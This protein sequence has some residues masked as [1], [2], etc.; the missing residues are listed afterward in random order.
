MGADINSVNN[1][2][3]TARHYAV[4]GDRVNTAELLIRLGADVNAQDK[5]GFAPLHRAAGRGYLDICKLLVDAGANIN[6]LDHAEETPLVHAVF[7]QQKEKFIMADDDDTPPPPPQKIETTSP[8]YLGAHD[9]SGDFITPVRLKLDNFDSWAHSIYVALSSRRKF[10]FLDDTI[11]DCIP[12]ATKEDWVVVHCIYARF[13][14]YK[15][16]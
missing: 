15:Y 9:R 5:V 8:F 14:A 7:C 6:V 13:M 2:D 1:V 12:P 3:R 11:I 16:H 10:G 4:S